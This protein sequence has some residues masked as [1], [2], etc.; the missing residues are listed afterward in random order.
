MPPGWRRLRLEL[1]YREHRDESGVADGN[2]EEFAGDM[3]LS[4][5]VTQDTA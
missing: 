3:I 1:A 2:F 4:R 5:A